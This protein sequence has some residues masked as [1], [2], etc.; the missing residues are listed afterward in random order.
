[1][2]EKSGPRALTRVKMWDHMFESLIITYMYIG[3]ES[4]I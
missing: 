3:S 1:M 2:I 4:F